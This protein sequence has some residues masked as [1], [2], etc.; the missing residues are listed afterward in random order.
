MKDAQHHPPGRESPHD[1]QSGVPTYHGK[2][3]ATKQHDST[4]SRGE[5]KLYDESAASIFVALSS[6]WVSLPDGTR[7]LAWCGGQK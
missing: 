7:Q 5:N 4:A 2:H 6:S 3:D 1:E